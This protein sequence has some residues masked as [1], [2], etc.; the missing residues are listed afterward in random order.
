MKDKYLANFVEDG[1]YH[2]YNRT[3]NKEPLFKTD[4]NRLYFLR[5][6]AK[7]VEPFV[8]TF[9][10]TLLPNHFHFLIK[11]KNSEDIKRHLK[12]VVI[13]KLKPIEKKYLDN[14]TTTELLLEFEWKRF[15]TS[16][17]MAF[18]K[19]HNRQGNLFHRP[20]KRV[21]VNKES[22]FTQAIIYI[23][24]NAFKHGVCKDFRQ[25]IWSSWRTITTSNTTKLCRQEV[26]DWFGG[27][28]RFIE[29][30]DKLAEFYYGGE[31]SIEEE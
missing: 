21:L 22:H 13:E 9:S 25:Y 3:N 6:F 19:Q 10:W 26:L 27:L 31:I 8:D 5:Q 16:Y 24:A 17:S 2:V 12:T 14:N 28:E 23:H 7:Y 18:N 1:I 15:L 11:V 20:F 4:E 29:A 30:H